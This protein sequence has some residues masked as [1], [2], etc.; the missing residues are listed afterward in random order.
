M[1]IAKQLKEKNIAEYLL[2]MW[3][4][5]DII[6][7]HSLNIDQLKESYLKKFQLKDAEQKAL[8]EWYQHL[9][10]MMHAEGIETKGHLQI[11]KNIIILLTDLHNELLKSTKF[12]FYTATYYKA[13]PY[14]VELRKKGQNK[15]TFEL[16]TCFEALYGVMMLRLQQKVISKE[17][18]LAIADITKLIASLSDYYRQDVNGKLNFE[19]Q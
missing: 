15:D 8:E 12:P 5:E 11:N 1:Y 13:L 14:I 16:E 3:Q 9:I 10:D 17:T 4:V 6:R 7:A 18:D 2:Y 19:Q